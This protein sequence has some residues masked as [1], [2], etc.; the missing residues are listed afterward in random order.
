MK[1][2]HRSDLALKRWSHMTAGQQTK[3]LGQGFMEIQRDSVLIVV[4]DNTKPQ[5]KELTEEEIKLGYA[6]KA[7]VE[8]LRAKDGD[9]YTGATDALFAATQKNYSNKPA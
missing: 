3:H 7:Y 6:D 1:T 8:H 2:F 9:R 5:R 4:K